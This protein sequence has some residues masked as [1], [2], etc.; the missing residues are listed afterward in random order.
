MKIE[1]NLKLIKKRLIS[2]EPL[3][4]I[5]DGED[6]GIYYYDETKKR[7]Q[8]QFGYFDMESMIEIFKHMELGEEY[9]VKLEVPNEADTNT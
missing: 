6:D 1:E 2:R 7:Y 9:F 8:G 4:V 5:Y 3:R